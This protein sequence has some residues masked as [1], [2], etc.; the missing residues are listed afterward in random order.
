MHCVSS[1][2][3]GQDFAEEPHLFHSQTKDQCSKTSKL[4][5]LILSS[6]I[7]CWGQIGI[8]QKLSH[9]SRKHGGPGQKAPGSSEQGSSSAGKF[10]LWGNTGRGIQ[11]VLPLTPRTWESSWITAML[12]SQITAMLN[13]LPQVMLKKAFRLS[14]AV[15]SSSL[16]K[17]QELT[18]PSKGN[19][20]N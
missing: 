7:S 6:N 16:H 14:T 11:L 5:R 12:N 15:I 4:W 8:V 1:K 13:S 2:G 3:Q 17:Q 20:V 10:H 19:L 9:H 18:A